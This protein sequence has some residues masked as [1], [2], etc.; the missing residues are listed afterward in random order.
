MELKR[1][2]L[3]EAHKALGA[4]LVAFA[5]W[6]MPVQYTGVIEEHLG[7]RK[8]CGLFDVSH[9]GEVEIA[10]P[11]AFSALQYLATNDLEKTVDGQCQYTLLC[12]PDGGVVDDCVVYRF[13]RERFLICVNASNTEKAFEWMKSNCP[14][15]AVVTDRSA[16]FAQ[17]ALQ[18]PSSA[19]VLRHLLSVDPAAVK[20][21]HFV[22]AK[23]AGVSA[24]ISRTGYTGED[25]FEIYLP[26]EEAAG[27]WQR[28]MEAG[29]RF[30]IVP[31]GLGARD[32]LRL[33]MGYP[34]YGHELTEKTTPIEAGLKRFVGLNKADFIGID[35]L[36]RQARSGVE[37]TLAGFEIEGQG[38]PR[39]GYDVCRGGKKL[40]S[41]TSGT[42]S[43]SL[44]KGVGMAYVEPALNKAGTEIDIIIRGRAVRARVVKPPFYTR[45]AV[46]LGA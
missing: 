25:G 15:G 40:G 22:E 42:H 34:L 37:K 19:E 27:V 44:G 7:V 30:K 12:Y 28:I 26:P 36:R 10:G 6:E 16:R 13:S 31:A 24:I 20:H 33:E 8:T 41:V 1:T 46:G 45:A 18:G 32:T 9:M 23:A 2:P 35:V 21:Y 14:K 5:G 43:P 38:V 17:L 4:R 29:A 3:Y 11:G 39:Q